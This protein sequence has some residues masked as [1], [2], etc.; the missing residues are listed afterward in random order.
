LA[1][2]FSSVGQH[3]RLRFCFL[4][5]LAAELDHEPASAFGE[6]GEPFGIDAFGAGVIDEEIVE[7][8]EADGMVLHDFGD[9]VGALKNVGIGNDQENAVGRAFDQAAGCF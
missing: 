6:Q 1:L 2:R 7:A 9:A 5:S 8:F 3:A 4:K